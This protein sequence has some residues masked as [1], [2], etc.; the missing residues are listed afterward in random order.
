MSEISFSVLL[1]RYLFHTWLF[2]DVTRG[3]L[4]E[5]AASWRHNQQQA[6]WL[7]RYIKRWLVLGTIAY[8]LGLLVELAM[9]SPVASAVFYVPSAL[10]VPIN[11]VLAASWLGLKLL[12]GPL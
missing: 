6:R 9:Q 1:Y 7:P 3:S 4:L 10:S 11:A 8:L 5:R 2:R 12:P